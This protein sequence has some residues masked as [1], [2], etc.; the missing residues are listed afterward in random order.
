[1]ITLLCSILNDMFYLNNFK[2]H[3][4]VSIFCFLRFLINCCPAQKSIK[5]LCQT[6][7][8]GQNVRDK[9]VLESCFMYLCVCTGAK[10]RDCGKV[11]GRP[12]SS[13]TTWRG[14]VGA[15]PSAGQVN[16][17]LTP[18]RLSGQHIASCLRCT[19]TQK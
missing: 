12:V 3:M 18:V 5:I 17:D 6:A 8:A 4:Y 11:S 9:A 19:F 1:M 14:L 13:N 15:E 10:E 7:R 16:R 2:L